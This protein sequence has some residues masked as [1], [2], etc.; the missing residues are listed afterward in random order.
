MS[1]AASATRAAWPAARPAATI[2][3]AWTTTATSVA[4]VERLARVLGPRHEVDGIEELTTLL[5]TLRGIFALQH[6]HQ[7]NLTGPAA[8]HVEGFHQARQTITLQL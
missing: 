8:D 7:S 4:A 3:P 1:A 2:A 5:C 6:A